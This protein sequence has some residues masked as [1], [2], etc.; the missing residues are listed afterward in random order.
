[1]GVY[2]HNIPVKKKM[3]EAVMYAIEAYADRLNLGIII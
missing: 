3:D 2:E 1:M